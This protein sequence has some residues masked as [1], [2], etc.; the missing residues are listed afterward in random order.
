MQTQVSKGGFEKNLFESKAIASKFAQLG[1]N[2]ASYHLCT[3]YSGHYG[4]PRNIKLAIRWCEEA[5]ED[6]YV[7]AISQLSWLYLQGSDPSL[8]SAMSF[9]EKAANLGNATGQRNY[10]LILS[11]LDASAY[12]WLINKYLV[13]A[14]INEDETAR[15]YLL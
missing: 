3:M 15:K 11:E 6:G 8:T 12:S 4:H 2:A 13:A 9:A 1:L 7:N 10:A 5:A 14:A